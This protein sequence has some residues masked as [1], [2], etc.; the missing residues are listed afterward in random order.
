M[1]KKILL[2]FISA[3]MFT[4]AML[5]VFFS[6]SKDDSNSKEKEKYLKKINALPE[7]VE[8]THLSYEDIKDKNGKV[9][10]TEEELIEKYS[11]KDENDQ[12]ILGKDVMGIVPIEERKKI[13]QDDL[14]TFIVEM[15]ENIRI[16][17][18]EAITSSIEKLNEK[19]NLKEAHEK[20][21][22]EMKYLEMLNSDASLMVYYKISYDRFDKY[23]QQTARLLPSDAYNENN[24]YNDARMVHNFRL[25]ETYLF[26]YLEATPHEANINTIDSLKSIL[27]FTEMENPLTYK[28]ISELDIAK[29]KEM[30]GSYNVLY[31]D[32]KK[33]H[34][35]DFIMKTS[36][37]TAY[38]LENND[39][40]LKMFHIVSTAKNN[41]FYRLPDVIK[42]R[43]NFDN[44][45]PMME[46]IDDSYLSL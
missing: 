38:I 39:G 29:T 43:D 3:A 30:L 45:R 4:L 20:Y 35:V 19:Y 8:K 28:S 31:K 13:N 32:V 17:K 36:D 24:Y 21:P 33:M 11:K 26:A 37:L 27:P 25:P 12:N 34:K 42:M 22:K 15:K 10:I 40:S 41:T 5:Y 9:I 16:G 44:K 23:I 46:G 1:N 14:R 18:F 2:I 6:F 7:E